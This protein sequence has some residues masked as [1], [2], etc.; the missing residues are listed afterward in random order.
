V[1]VRGRHDLDQVLAGV[2]EVD[3]QDRL[4]GAG[5]FDRAFPDRDA[6]CGEDRDHLIQR[7]GGDQAQVRAAGPRPMGLRLE[8]VAGAVQVDLA[9]TEGQRA[10]LVP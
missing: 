2:A 9:A 7:P 5:A 8:L 3:G 4:C 6:V 1:R 10:G